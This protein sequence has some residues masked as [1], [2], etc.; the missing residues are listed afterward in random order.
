LNGAAASDKNVETGVREGPEWQALQLLLSM[1]GGVAVD[2][3]LWTSWSWPG[4]NPFAAL[5]GTSEVY[6][7]ARK[8]P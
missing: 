4:H 3:F 8:S 5:S 6:D 7:G 2:E 1:P